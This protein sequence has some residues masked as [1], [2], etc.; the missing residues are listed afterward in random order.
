MLNN[1]LSHSA[2]L[3]AVAALGLLLLAAVLGHQSVLRVFSRPGITVDTS[4]AEVIRQVRAL[5]RLETAS[6]SVDKVV[7]AGTSGNVLQQALFGDRILLLARGEAAAGFDLSRLK[8]GDICRKGST[9]VVR[10]PRPELLYVRLDS[11]RTR[12][13]DRR[14]G[15]LS[16]GSK[17]LESRARLAAETAIG[18]SAREGGLLQVAAENGR[19]R[20]AELLKSAGIEDVRVVAGV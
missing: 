15:L 13:Y 2:A 5:N 10:L 9:V 14:V 8:D 1:R 11:V 19:K 6:F 4:R 3:A 16:R 20:V 18:Q 12:V 17:D 7:E